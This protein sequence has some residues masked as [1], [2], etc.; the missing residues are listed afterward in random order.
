MGLGLVV[1]FRPHGLEAHEEPA[2]SGF[3]VWVLGLGFIEL[4]I[5]GSGFKFKVSRRAV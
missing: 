1:A 5:Q 2:G 3:R 4:G